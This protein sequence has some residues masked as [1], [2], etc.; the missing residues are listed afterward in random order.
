M[1]GMAEAPAGGLDVGLGTL[2]LDAVV[3]VQQGIQAG[4][5]GAGGQEDRQQK[6]GLGPEKGRSPSGDQAIHV[7][8]YTHARSTAVPRRTGPSAGSRNQNAAPRP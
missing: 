1:I 6:E 3:V 2:E 8:E 5:A 7:V 4:Q